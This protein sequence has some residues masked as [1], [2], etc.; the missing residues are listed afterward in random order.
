M[1][2]T[3]ALLGAVALCIAALASCGHSGRSSGRRP[4]TAVRLSAHRPTAGITR[5]ARAAQTSGSGLATYGQ[6]ATPQSL[7]AIS[8]ALQRYLRALASDR[9][10][11]ACRQLTSS[12]RAQVS[13]VIP[14][15]RPGLREDCPSALRSMFSHETPHRRVALRGTIITAVRVEAD[16]AFVLFRQPGMPSGF[17][18]MQREAGRWRIAAL[19]ASLLPDS[20]D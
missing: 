15:T 12:L 2:R 17:F 10:S 4:T 7:A 3:A 11:A 9:G 13:A 16:R 8:T 5:T 14:P 1:I 6:Q 18:P 20:H 19:G